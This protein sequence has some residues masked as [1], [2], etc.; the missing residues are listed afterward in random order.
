MTE[1]GTGTAT[2]GDLFERAVAF[3]ASESEIREVLERRRGNGDESKSES[4]SG[5]EAEGGDGEGNA[6]GSDV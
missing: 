3:E 2:W 4:E 1:S 5:S 6:E